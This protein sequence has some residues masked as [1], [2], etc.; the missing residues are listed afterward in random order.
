MSGPTKRKATT[1]AP[2][3]RDKNCKAVAPPRPA[4]D[5]TEKFTT[6]FADMLTTREQVLDAKVFVEHVVR[7]VDVPRAGPELITSFYKKIRKDATLQDAMRGH[8]AVFAQGCKDDKETAVAAVA[9]AIKDRHFGVTRD[10]DD[11]RAQRQ[12]AELFSK[13]ET[14]E[15]I[16]E[17]VRGMGIAPQ[18][19]YKQRL[20]YGDGDGSCE[21]A[22]DQAL[23]RGGL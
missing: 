21:S 15:V 7:S 16:A 3:A 10:R 20:S 18:D 23:A 22:M 1:P 19:F 6:R 9:S 11:Q 8:Y 4:F 13:W 14:P 5:P 17:K 2:L 12:N